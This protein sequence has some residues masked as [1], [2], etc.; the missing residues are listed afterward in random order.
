MVKPVHKALRATLLTLVVLGTGACAIL[1]FTSGCA[2]DLKTG[3]VGSSQRALELESLSLIPGA[4]GLGAGALFV[5]FRSAATPTRRFTNAL[6][7]ALLG[8]VVLWLAGMQLQL[9]GTR[10]CWAP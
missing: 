5:W 9:W 6:G 8:M 4:L 2:G 7:F 3:A 10:E 1:A